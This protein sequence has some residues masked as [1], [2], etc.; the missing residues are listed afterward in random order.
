[1]GWQTDVVAAAISE[2][3]SIANM[4][5]PAASYVGFTFNG[6]DRVNVCTL[7]CLLEANNSLECFDKHL[8]AMKI[9]T[10]TNEE[11]P[12]V[13]VIAPAQV[14]KLADVASWD[15]T[16]F[17]VLAK[18]WRSTEEFEG[19]VESDVDDLLQT[20]VDLAETAVLNKQTVMI[21]QSP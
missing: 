3:Q 4:E 7:L 2:S 13:T 21:W 19:W 8:D 9:V 16:R 10:R 17:Q 15:A 1:M 12:T 6:F 14:E 20:F 18:Q 11:W 5:S